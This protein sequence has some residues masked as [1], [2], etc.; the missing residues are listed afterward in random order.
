AFILDD[1]LNQVPFTATYPKTGGNTEWS[2][3][4]DLDLGERQT[5][6]FRY[7]LFQQSQGNGG[8]GQFEL[9]SQAYDSNATEQTFQFSDTQSYG[10]KLLNETRFQY[11]RDRNR[12]RPRDTG[13]TIVVQGGFTG[14]G[15][16]QGATDDNQDHY[17]F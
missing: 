5:L 16:N 13:P 6:S 9:A 3:R 7:Q 2:T 17:E 14:G 15:S 1:K 8:V 10:V 11:I 12:Q 4:F